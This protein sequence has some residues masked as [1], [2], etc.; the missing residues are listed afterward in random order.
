[1][2]GF[3]CVGVEDPC[4]VA[5]VRVIGDRDWSGQ[6][7]GE[8]LPSSSRGISR[9]TTGGFTTDIL[10]NARFCHNKAIKPSESSSK[11]ALLTDPI[12]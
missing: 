6:W 10:Q 2:E 1:M 9:V 8:P 5:R 4:L 3:L 11:L 7:L 12:C